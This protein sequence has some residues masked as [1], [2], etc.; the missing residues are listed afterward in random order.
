MHLL[1][2]CLAVSG[3]LSTS[4]ALLIDRSAELV[5][6]PLPVHGRPWRRSLRAPDSQRPRVASRKHCRCKAPVQICLSR[7]WSLPTHF[8]RVLEV[9]PQSIHIRFSLARVTPPC[10]RCLLPLATHR[11]QLS[12]DNRGT[13]ILTPPVALALQVC[14]REVLEKTLFLVGA[15]CRLISS[16]TSR[17]TLVLPLLC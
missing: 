17:F 11:L 12:V 1:T 4:S 7:R 6:S 16:F 2:R 5:E 13:P 15:H 9:R 10:S 3:H 14:D 8:E